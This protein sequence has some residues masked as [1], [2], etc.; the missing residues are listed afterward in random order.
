MFSYILSAIIYRDED[1]SDNVFLGFKR[2][3]FPDELLDGDLYNAWNDIV[4]LIQ[5]DK[6]VETYCYTKDGVQRINETGVPMTSINFPKSSQYK[7]F[8][9]GTSGNSTQKP[10]KLKGKAADGGDVISMYS[11]Q[12]WLK[13]SYVTELLK[14]T[15]YI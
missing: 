10:W 3:V 4:D 15:D 13:G 14:E 12:M 7:A 5:N 9:R 6:L 11:Q 2:I 8:L 1:Y